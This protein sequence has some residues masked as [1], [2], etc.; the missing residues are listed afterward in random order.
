MTPC[1]LPRMPIAVAMHVSMSD[2]TPAWGKS[3]QL[4]SG[5]KPPAQKSNW[6]Y[7]MAWD[8]GRLVVAGDMCTTLVQQPCKLI[9][10]QV[11]HHS[12]VHTLSCDVPTVWRRPQVLGDLQSQGIYEKQAGGKWP[13]RIQIATLRQ[14]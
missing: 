13:E 12:H 1:C 2:G 6:H 5:S 7:Y 9:R 14:H 10:R 8:L 4:T 3:L 11:R